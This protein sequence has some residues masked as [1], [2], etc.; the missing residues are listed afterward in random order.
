MTTPRLDNGPSGVDSDV[1]WDG[2]WSTLEGRILL[3]GVALGTLTVL[4]LLL[5]WSGSPARHAEVLTMALTHLTVGRAAAMSLGY[6]RD[7]GHAV[8][9]GVNLL[10]EFVLV[11]VFY[12]LFVLSFRRLPL[13]RPLRGA[14]HRAQGAAERRQDLVQRFGMIGLF[15][16]VWAPFWMTG[17]VVGSF[18]GHLMGFPA[19]ANLAIVLGGTTVAIFGWAFFLSELTELSGR[20]G[21]WGPLILIAALVVAVILGR[22][23]RSRSTSRVQ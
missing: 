11:L 23:L 2:V 12:P 13:V 17:P 4:G 18:I 1:G 9:I 5:P 7:L 14:I 6:A 8:I 20:G 15:F 22:W 21:A 19:G 16:F 3:V 10:I